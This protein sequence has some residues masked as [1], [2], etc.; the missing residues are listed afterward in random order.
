MFIR[1]Q[2]DD[3]CIKIRGKVYEKS[4]H[5]VIAILSHYSGGFIIILRFVYNV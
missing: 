1:G 2:A 4:G 5:P 3:G